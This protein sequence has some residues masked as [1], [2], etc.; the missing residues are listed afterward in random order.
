MSGLVAIISDI[1]GNLQALEAVLE[2]VAE[3]DCTTTYCLGDIVGYG[4]RPAECIDLLRQHDIAS[5]MGNHD[6][7]ICGIED[8][9]GFNA[10]ALESGKY[11]RRILSPEH[12]AYLRS[13]PED[14]VP[15]PRVLMTHGAPGD[16]NRYLLSRYEFELVADSLA[17]ADVDLCFVGHTH[18][19]CVFAGKEILY[20][21]T[22]TT[23]LAETPT[24]VN[25]G[26]VGQPRDRDSRA[27]FV[28]WQPQ[29]QTVQFER[30]RYDTDRARQDIIDAGLPQALGDRLLAGR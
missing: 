3:L 24:V 2:R 11:C 14:I 16:R 29:Q 4:A 13:Q 20:Y 27:S 26:S 17:A 18:L 9:V 15:A 30:V 21:K 25:P 6:A 5:I 12:I 7:L 19:P 22:E 10:L 8:G 28:V 23:S 1:H